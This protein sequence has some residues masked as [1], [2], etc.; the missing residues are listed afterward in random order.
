MRANWD[1]SMNFQSIWIRLSPYLLVLGLAI[2]QM[3]KF[4]DGRMAVLVLGL[5]VLQ[6]L[7]AW[8]VAVNARRSFP[9]LSVCIEAGLLF[10]AALV[11]SAYTV[12]A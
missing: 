8:Q 7:M 1:G 4:P 5:V 10:G 6:A 11:V 12:F 3:S 9:V 2:M